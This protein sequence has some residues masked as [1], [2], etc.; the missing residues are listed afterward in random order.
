MQA[1]EELQPARDEFLIRFY[2]WAKEF[3]Q[4][5]FS[6]G[7]PLV[8]QIRNPSAARLVSFAALLNVGERKL[9]CH[10]LLKRFHP[11]AAKLANDLPSSEEEAILRR[12]SAA[13]KAFPI[14][15]FSEKAQSLPKTRLRKM[16]LNKLRVVLGDPIDSP[17]HDEWEY[18]VHFDCW[19]VSTRIDIGGRRV[20]GYE[21]AIRASESV[22]L[23][24]Q[25]SV[26]SWMGIASQT[27]WVSMSEAEQEKT[28]ESIGHLC[29]LFMD[30]APMLLKGLSCP[31]EEPEV[32]EWNEVFTVESHRINGYTMLLIQS[33]DLR[34]TLGQKASWEIPTSII[35]DAL[36]PVGSQFRV[37]QDP[38]YV[39]KDGDRLAMLPAYRH[40]RVE[41]LG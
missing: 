35:P 39:R 34:H 24:R 32:R 26:L 30:T 3:S 17:D 9:L 18:R 14:D 7:F 21:H 4:H 12:Y 16:L 40:L 10:A 22:F 13:R 31:L 20:L 8:S 19:N 33:P 11:R 38:T 23:H 27:D 36:R 25:I 5:E 29:K 2:G 15:S 41:G 28:L 37:I 1:T 6:H